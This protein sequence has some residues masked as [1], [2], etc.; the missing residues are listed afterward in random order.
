MSSALRGARLSRAA[1]GIYATHDVV[2][3]FLGH[4]YSAFQIIFFSGRL[5]FPFVS[6]LLMSDK[7]DANLVPRHPWLSLAR[8]VLENRSRLDTGTMPRISR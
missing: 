7:R 8:S 4:P 6:V 5:S 3:K 1:F 2:V